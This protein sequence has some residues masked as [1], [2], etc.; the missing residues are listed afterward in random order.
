MFFQ[1]LKTRR[2]GT[3][4]P[5]RGI[6]PIKINNFLFFIFALVNE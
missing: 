3:P 4:T 5:Q 6:M 1:E 2:Q